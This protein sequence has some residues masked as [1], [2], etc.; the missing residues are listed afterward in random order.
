MSQNTRR[1]ST[2]LL[3]WTYVRY[4]LRWHL[5]EGMRWDGMGRSRFLG[6]LV[7]GRGRTGTSLTL[8]SGDGVVPP[9]RRDDVGRGGMALVR[10]LLSTCCHLCATAH[11]RRP[12]HR[13]ARRRGGWGGVEAGRSVAG[14]G[15]GDAGLAHAGRRAG[16]RRGGLS[17]RWAGMR[18]GG[19]SAPPGEEETRRGRR[20]GS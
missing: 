6:C 20:R 2:F 8:N 9:I 15:G 17:R 14:R 13:A 7:G 18:R 5:V 16:R 3:L 1:V 19:A 12:R 10:F 4:L 11:R